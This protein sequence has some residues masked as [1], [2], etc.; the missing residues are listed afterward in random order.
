MSVKKIENQNETKHN[1][2]KMH[3]YKYVHRTRS[4]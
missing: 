3:T 4:K 2:Y 1:A